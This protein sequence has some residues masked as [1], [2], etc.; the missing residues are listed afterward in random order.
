MADL[1]PDAV[2]VQDDGTVGEPVLVLDKAHECEPRQT[3]AA[4]RGQAGPVF[5]ADGLKPN[6]KDWLEAGDSDHNG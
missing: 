6:E 5:L 3:S 4:K 2:E 1:H